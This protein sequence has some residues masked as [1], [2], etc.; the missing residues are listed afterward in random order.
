[1]RKATMRTSPPKVQK[2]FIL[3]VTK[4]IGAATQLSVSNSSDALLVIHNVPA[5]RSRVRVLLSIVAFV[6]VRMLAMLNEPIVPAM[7]NKLS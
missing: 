6:S 5:G 7:K 4:P 1:M 2:V 3:L